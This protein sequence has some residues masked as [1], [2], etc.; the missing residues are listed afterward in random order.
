MPID[1][2]TERLVSLSEVPKLK[3]LPVRRRGKR[4]HV[5]CVFRWT[6]TG[7]RGVVLESI[8]IGGTR[9]TSQEALARFFA[10]LTAAAASG[11]TVAR[12]SLERDREIS[13]AER[14]LDQLGIAPLAEASRNTRGPKVNSSVSDSSST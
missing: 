3:F 14:R 4:P 7:C 6:K 13:L 8:Q 12:G 11:E 1:P 9:C 5:S 10:A 2:L